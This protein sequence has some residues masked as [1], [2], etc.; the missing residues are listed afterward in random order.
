M[1]VNLQCC[2]QDTKFVCC[3]DNP[4]KGYAYNLY[5]C[6]LCGT[7]HKENVWN[8]KG[9]TA[10]PAVPEPL[11]FHCAY[12][13]SLATWPTINPDLMKDKDWPI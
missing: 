10:I 3:W 9:I 12:D 7:L 4:E 6:E 5:Q 8:D 1:P 2:S 13:V 11:S